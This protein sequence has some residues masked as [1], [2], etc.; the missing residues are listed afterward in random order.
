M[1]G[2]TG[3]NYAV[4]IKRVF[5][6]YLQNFFTQHKTLTWNSNPALSNII[7]IDKNTVNLAHAESRP[8]I[9]ISRGA[10][11]W[12]YTSMG[13][14]PTSSFLAPSDQKFAGV[15][16][17]KT[18][19]FT[20]LL[21]GNLTINCLARNG[22][23]A[24]TLANHVFQGLTVGKEHLREKGGIHSIDSLSMGEEQILKSDSSIELTLVPVQLS[25]ASQQ[26][27]RTG[28]QHYNITLKDNNGLYYYQGTDFDIADDLIT[29]TFYKAPETGLTLAATYTAFDDS[30]GNQW[31]VTDETITGTIDGVNKVFTVANTIYGAPLF[32]S[33]AGFNGE[34]IIDRGSDTPINE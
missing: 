16:G 19:V 9:V 3:A 32:A 13:Q 21:R 1:L 15:P 2:F 24:E 4:D 29:L 17:S 5:L 14:R 7:I 33:M 6:S 30:N 31:D 26:W 34:P 23:F 12:S 28:D 11:G 20:D 27:L 10:F 8:T 22:I 18:R 25:Y